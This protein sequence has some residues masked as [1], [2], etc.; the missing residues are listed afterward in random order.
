M[1][2]AGLDFPIAS[3]TI[4]LGVAVDSC[5]SAA[6]IVAH[7]LAAA[8]RHWQARRAQL[9]HRR[10]P[11]RAHVVRWY[12]TVAKTALWGLCAAKPSQLLLARVRA[13]ELRCLRAMLA[14]GRLDGESFAD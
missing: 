10:A 13:F 1:S 12:L 8:E 6:A 5:G 9:C 3:E 4:L 14:R 7:R 2:M 11:L